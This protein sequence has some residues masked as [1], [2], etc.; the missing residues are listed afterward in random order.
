MTIP[1][2][3]QLQE[4]VDAGLAP[5]VRWL[6]DQIRAGRIPARKRA[7]CWVM[8]DADIEACLQMWA[9][10]AAAAPRPEPDVAAVFSL[11]PTSRRKRTA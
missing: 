11:T 10:K 4:L 7:R 5:S 6:K 9:N 2:A 3:H 1:R 8:T